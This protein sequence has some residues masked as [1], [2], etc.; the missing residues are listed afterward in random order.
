MHKK[1]CYLAISFLFLV[2]LGFFLI[3]S[4]KKITTVKPIAKNNEFIPKE[5]STK[6]VLKYKYAIFDISGCF[7]QKEL[8]ELLYSYQKRKGIPLSYYFKLIRYGI[9][10]SI[11]SLNTKIAYEDFL[12][13]CK[14]ESIEKL[15]RDCALTWEKDCK[16]FILKDAV[17]TF[18]ECKKNKI[19]TIL[20]ETGMKEIYSELLK[21]YPFDYV[22]TSEVEFKNGGITGKLL[23]EP[24]SGKEKYEKVKNIIEKKL[25]GSLRDAVFYSNS[26]QDIQLLEAVGKPVAVNPTSK[27]L[28]YAKKKGWE[29]LQ[30]KEI[31]K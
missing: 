15:K 28:A 24:C 5:D 9:S 2:F 26:H 18:E 20:A 4:V 16:N 25:G 23:G 31:L 6:K 21:K 27:L 30:Y 14:G 13:Y 3:G 17:K 29:I 12:N 22:C 10:Y 1:I 7:W 8:Y 19:I 11:G